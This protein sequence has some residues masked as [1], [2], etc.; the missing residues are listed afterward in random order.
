MT[1]AKTLPF[2][3]TSEELE[4]YLLEFARLTGGIAGRHSGSGPSTGLGAGW[5]VSGGALLSS[6]P[7]T[8]PWTIDVTRECD[9]LAVSHRIRGV[10]WTRAK[11]SRIGS[12]REGQL[13]DYLTARVRGSG[14]EKF[15]AFRLREPFAPVGDGVAAGTASFTWIVLTGLAV[16]AF[17]YAAAV[18]VSLPLM[19]LSIREIAAHADALRQ[20]G[21]IPLPSPAEAAATSALG[22]SIVF[23]FPIAFFAALVH[24]AALA[25]SELG[26]RAARVPQASVLFLTVLI[27][28]GFFPFLPVLALP[29]A[30][31]V[32]AAAHLGATL[33]WGRRRERVRQGPRPQKAVVLIAVI[34]AASLAGAVVPRGAPW[35]ENMV[36]IALF[37][38]AWL[39]G[40]PAG[41]A[42]ASAY[43]RYTLYTA[44]PVKVLYSADGTQSDRQQPIAACADPAAANP[45]RAL[46]FTVTS[47]SAPSDVVVGPGGIP[48]GKDLAELKAALDEHSRRT[49]RG[50]WLR[51]L[52]TLGWYSLYYAGP[53]AVL[54]VLM[55]IFSPF[56]SILFRKLAPRTAVVAL[57]GGTMITILLLVLIVENAPP[58]TDPAVLADALT[59]ARPHR[60]REAA[61]RAY[62]LDST[63]PMA[64]A[65]LR[66]A[67]DSDFRVR[68]WACAALG[69]SGDPRALPKLVERLD[70]PELF[71]RYRAA[72]GLQFLKDP[73][74]VDSLVRVMK[75][76]SWYE[77]VYALDA[78]RKIR[79]GAF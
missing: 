57:S 74:A 39:L 70:D 58:V 28:L 34:L 66:A 1:A 62:R 10:P 75:E 12:F 33:V 72:Q 45:L 71:V 3:G 67:D 73:G 55:G 65:L 18:L 46:G 48:P 69:K 60:R 31:I 2:A 15:D 7:N 78:L 77:G 27:G 63:A 54:V 52:T 43:Y 30:P 16:F 76:R 23:A 56:I 20:A 8:I 17:A 21:A 49:F 42:I 38:D 51:D 24:S 40:N 41:K 19:S 37:R 29:L 9:G 61:F 35:K 59:D 53:V 22:A 26:P 5:I 11:A 47:P 32:P 4:K 36:R 64:G 25:S 44:E 6:N 13:A 50:R 68:L 14:P 79:P